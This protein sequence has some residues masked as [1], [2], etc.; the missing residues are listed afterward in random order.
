[1]NCLSQRIRSGKLTIARDSRSADAER[2]FLAM[3]I[4]PAEEQDIPSIAR[5]HV[6]SWRTTYR[7]ILADSFLAGLSYQKHED[8]HRRYMAQPGGFHY[9][10]DLPAAG[11]VG[12]LMGGPERS[13]DILFPGELYA[14]YILEQHR[15]QGIGSALIQQ[16]AG[17]L[18]RA[19]LNSALVWVLQANKSAAA[20]YQRLGSIQIREQ[21]IDIGGSS[22]K[23]IAY[24]WNDLSAMEHG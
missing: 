15:R 21:M 23:E 24:G 17:S 1:M 12:F 2:K 11:I 22:L 9:V 16:W 14:I 6:E 10:A 13:G 4:R 19:G 5:V 7:G 3:I 8:R 20:F 18:R